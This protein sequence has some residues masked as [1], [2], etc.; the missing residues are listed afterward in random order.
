MQDIW[1]LD[2]TDWKVFLAATYDSS[3]NKSYS[4]APIR[5]LAAARA[6]STYMLPG[7]SVHTVYPAT[8]ILIKKA[9]LPLLLHT[10]PTSAMH[11]TTPQC[12]LAP[13]SRSVVTT[14]Q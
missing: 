7:T 11:N 5:L 8:M 14:D 1:L 9:S 2:N 10:V 13:R 4:Q 3:M 12:M 6:A